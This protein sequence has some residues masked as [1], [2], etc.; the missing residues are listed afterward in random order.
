MTSTDALYNHL[1]QARELAQTLRARQPE[2]R[3]PNVAP[4]VVI[5]TPKIATGIRRLDDLLGGG[6]PM[7]TTT[8]LHGAPY[9]GKSAAQR[10]FF[11]QG[12]RSQQPS[13]YLLTD[14]SA[15][16][17]SRK[18]HSLDPEVGNLEKRDLCAYIDVYTKLI[19]EKD[20]HKHAK[21]VDEAHRWDKVLTVIERT[22]Q[23]QLRKHPGPSRL[24]IE[25][26]SS[27]MMELGPA[28]TFRFLR[29]LLGRFAKRG[30]TALVAIDTG[31][32]EG[33]EIE[34]IKH[35]CRGMIS[36]RESNTQ[37]FLRIEGIPTEFAPGWVE[38]EHDERSFDVT[39]SFASGRIRGG[40]HSASMA[41]P[42]Q[43]TP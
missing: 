37:F 29:A 34:T 40:Q 11:L 23:Q 19:G 12:L 36:L 30:G 28:N 33:H 2:G 27:L 31:M 42:F 17:M 35:L 24:V 14:T 41:M 32:H 16:E 38:Y 9:T 22:H 7:G 15:S 13:I 43:V 5:G 39:G 1:L 3:A 10:T 6:L 8:L 25:S 26:I 20:K 21:Y 18:L 4:S